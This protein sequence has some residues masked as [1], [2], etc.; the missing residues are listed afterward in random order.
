MIQFAMKQ[1]YPHVCKHYPADDKS[2][3]EIALVAPSLISINHT[4]FSDGTD[5]HVDVDVE[6]EED[7]QQEGEKCRVASAAEG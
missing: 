7:Q 5:V 3:E 2:A 6:K 1:H 4:H